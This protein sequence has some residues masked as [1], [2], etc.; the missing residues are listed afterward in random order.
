MLYAPFRSNSNN[1]E[2]FYN[3]INNPTTKS[4]V[5][6]VTTS[7]KPYTPGTVVIAPATTKSPTS[8]TNS[9]TSTT[10]SHTSTTNSPTSTTNSSTL[11]K[12]ITS[13]TNSP[14]STTSSPTISPS[15]T[16][17]SLTGKSQ[18]KSLF[19][20]FINTILFPINI[21]RIDNNKTVPDE[22]TSN[23]NSNTNNVEEINFGLVGIFMILFIT[24]F[25]ALV[26]TNTILKKKI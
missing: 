2:C 3:V 26:S 1:Y 17:S 24:I 7:K 20:Y 11:T 8:T 18:S 15:T 10:N 13:S 16:K 9:P 5:I 12:S 6:T 21:F 4:P 14:T 22:N 19:A 25:L 23:Q